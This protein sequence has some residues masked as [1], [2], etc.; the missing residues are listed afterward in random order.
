M[1]GF[2]LGGVGGYSLATN[3]ERTARWALASLGARPSLDA[4]RQQARTQRPLAQSSSRRLGARCRPRVRDG[5]PTSAHPSRWR[6]FRGRTFPRLACACFPR[7]HPAPCA[8]KKWQRARSPS[9][10]RVNRSRIA[11]RL[12]CAF[13]SAVCKGHESVHKTPPGLCMLK[14]AGEVGRWSLDWAAAC[15]ASAPASGLA[16]SGALLCSIAIALCERV[17]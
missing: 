2:S 13:A 1:E 12:V 15:R 7:T 10:S 4:D 8:V 17:L 11:S 3:R 5:Q 14:I 6:D 16:C 9:R